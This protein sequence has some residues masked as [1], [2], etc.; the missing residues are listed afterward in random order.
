MTMSLI[1]IGYLLYQFTGPGNYEHKYLTRVINSYDGYRKDAAH[2]AAL[3]TDALEQAAADRNLFANSQRAQN[4]TLRFPEY[5]RLSLSIPRLWHREAQSTEQKKEKDATVQEQIHEV[6]AKRIERL[7]KFCR[8]DSQHWSSS[9]RAR[10]SLRRHVT[11]HCQVREGGIRGQ[12]KEV[13]ADQGQ[14]CPQRAPFQGPS[15][16]WRRDCVDVDIPCQQR[17]H[18]FFS[19]FVIFVARVKQKC[20]RCYLRQAS[21]NSILRLNHAGLNVHVV[22]Q[23]LSRVRSVVYLEA[24]CLTLLV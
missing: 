23:I 8:Q 19:I 1:P 18:V 20:C 17:I 7:T 12:R 10:R 5:V 4:V 11:S 2:I 13:A 24:T 15:S 16:H 3:H 6:H 21:Q 9:Q 14:R 22:I